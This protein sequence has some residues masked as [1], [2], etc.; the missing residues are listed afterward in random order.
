MGL[1]SRSGNIYYYEQTKD[2]G[3]SQVKRC[4]ITDA[5][6]S[7]E[8]SQ[9]SNGDKKWIKYF[10]CDDSKCGSRQHSTCVVIPEKPVEGPNPEV[11][12]QFYCEAGSRNQAIAVEIDPLRD[13]WILQK[14][15]AE[16]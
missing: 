4:N 5:N 2:S 7:Y 13:Q 11:P 8:R 15:A 9:Q 1:L 10:P 3:Y 6:Y 16:R 12:S 14:M